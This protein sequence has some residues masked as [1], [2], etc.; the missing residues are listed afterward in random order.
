MQKWTIANADLCCPSK[1]SLGR[2]KAH[3]I[4]KE[5][6]SGELKMCPKSWWAGQWRSQDLDLKTIRAQTRSLAQGHPGREHSSDPM[7]PRA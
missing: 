4:D 7:N 2:F 5:T 6:G 3:F 1:A